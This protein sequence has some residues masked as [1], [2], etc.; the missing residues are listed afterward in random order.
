L[1]EQKR[2]LWK[3]GFEEQKED[4]GSKVLKNYKGVRP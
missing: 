4:F 1:K 2:R 3:W